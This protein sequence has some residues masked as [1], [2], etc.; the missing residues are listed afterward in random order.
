MFVYRKDLK[1]CGDYWCSPQLYFDEYK[2]FDS[3]DILDIDDNFN[4][5]DFII[6]GGGGLGKKLFQDK[7]NSLFEKLKI[8]YLFAGELDLTI[9]II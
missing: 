9:M 3:Y 5:S 6:L 1:N 8:K 4:F 2:N 7:I